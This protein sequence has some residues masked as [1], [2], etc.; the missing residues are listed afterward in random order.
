MNT[1]D[2]NALDIR[3]KK[4]EQIGLSRSDNSDTESNAVDLNTIWHT[5][6][7][8]K[9]IILGTCLAMIAAFAGYTFM[10]APEYEAAATVQVE[11]P[12]QAQTVRFDIQPEL[13]SEIGILTNSGSLA[14]RVITELRTAADTTDT[15]F[16]L[17]AAVDDEQPTD[18]EAMIRL[19]DMV[20]FAAEADQGLIRIVARSQY[21]EEA[22]AVANTYADAYRA[23]SR[24]S[25]RAGVAAAREFLETQLDRREEDIEE[26]ENEWQQF[27]RRHDVAIDGQDGNR[28]ATDYVEMMGQRDQLEFQLQ[29]EQRTLDM[30]VNQLNEAESSFRSDVEGEQ[31]VQSMQNRIA[32]LD[33]Q[34]A[35]LEAQA[36]PYYINNPDLR[37]NEDQV[38]ELSQIKRQIEG[39]EDRK[40][41]LTAEMVELAADPEVRVGQGAALGRLTELRARIDEQEATV[42]QLQGQVSRLNNRIGGYEDRIEEIP[43]QTVERE[44]LARRLDQAERFYRDIAMELQR[45]IVTEESEL[46]YVQVIRSAS[47]PA[48]PVSPNI[49]QNLILG[50]LLGLAFGIGGAFVRQAMNW[51]IYDPEDIQ[52][53]GFSLVGVIPD[54]KREIKSSFNGKESVDVEGRQ[55][56][57]SLMPLL[58]PW[59]PVT[60]NYRLIRTN[61]QFA[62]ANVEDMPEVL[63]ITSPEPGDGKSTTAVNLAITIALSGRSALLIDGDLRRP[64]THKMLGVDRSPGLAEMLT[65]STQREIVQRTFIENLY[66]VPA[67]TVKVPP[68]ELLDSSRMR[69]LVALG[70]SR[71]DVVIIDTP[72]VLGA[73][74]ALVVSSLC[75]AVL[76]VA[77]ANKTDLRALKSVKETFAGVNVPLAGV[78]FNRFDPAQSQG[79]YA[80]GYGYDAAYSYAPTAEA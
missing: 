48:L 7:R 40:E 8:G 59:S 32:A 52:S 57:T 5:I 27:A 75:D 15:P 61:L 28:V 45:T 74:D 73:T 39:L 18:S 65:D 50:L 77:S 20:D 38:R 25:A 64:T 17:F 58:N 37:G 22:A 1:N 70:R 33:Q 42:R 4:V 2:Q 56:S 41:R 3:R 9:W 35:D 36:E 11:K 29:E 46:G 23:Y 62:Q 30:L 44:Q 19:F 24:E 16:Q 53:Q 71:C 49:Q 13:S 76:V 72:P 31:S 78:I 55:L 63:M 21:P 47:I 69:Q 43:E 51:Q 68:T 66:Y 6:K 67:G 14:M 60:E 12:N 34:I 54:M 80:Y 26:V 10:V 79:S